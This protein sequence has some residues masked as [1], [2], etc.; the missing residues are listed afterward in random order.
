MLGAVSEIAAD[1][2]SHRH[3]LLV[4]EVEHVPPLLLPPLAPPVRS[5]V[6]S[7]SFT[8]PVCA[9]PVCCPD[10]KRVQV[11]SKL[12][13]IHLIV[14]FNLLVDPVNL[15]Q[16]VL[17]ARVGDRTVILKPTELGRVEESRHCKGV[18]GVRVV[19]LSQLG[20]CSPQVSDTF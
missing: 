8:K 11:R 20:D 7:N 12:N 4:T 18:L 13:T 5:S 10:S 1:M 15:L 6:F 14:L 9:L 17:V 3:P 2:L 19:I 16:L